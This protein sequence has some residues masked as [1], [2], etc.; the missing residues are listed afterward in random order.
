MRSSC[1]HRLAGALLLACSG[2]VAS[3]APSA[4]QLFATRQQ[5]SANSNNFATGDIL[6]WGANSVT[7]DTSYAFTRQCPSGASCTSPSDPDYIRQAIYDRPFTTSPTQY[8]AS[9]PYSASLTGAWTLV[10]SSDPSFPGTST[11]LT[12]VVN[13]PAV[14]DVALMPYVHSMSITGAGLTPTISWT[15]PATTPVAVDQVRIRIYDNT[16]RITTTS[17]TPSFPNQFTQADS[18]FASPVLAPDAS[19]YALP[20]GL[21]AYNT[22]Y[23]IAVSLEH[24]RADGSVDSRSLSYFDFTPVDLP[25]APNVALPTFA[26]VPTTS[27]ATAG[28]LYGFQVAD[29]GPDHVSFIDP[30]VASGFSYVKGAGD[31]NFKSVTIATNAGDGLYDVYVKVAGNWTLARSGLA[32]NEAFEFGVGGVD[33]FEIRGIETEAALNPFSVTAFITG[34]SF[35]SDGSFTGTMQAIVVDTA[36]VPEPAPLAML[37]GG[38]SL[39]GGLLRRRR[40]NGN[41]ASA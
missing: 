28:P 12:T 29:V 40:L 20:A 38:G 4:T 26:P 15:L 2:L 37:L 41:A 22:D 10:L 9:R 30:L 34:L 21:L 32:A 6:Y 11:G 36:A 5:N 39:L 24:K 8:F 14:G 25:G 18:I 13:T 16:N 1:A 33:S 17:R 3:A 27:G 35:V 7:P 31:P 23:S 19:G